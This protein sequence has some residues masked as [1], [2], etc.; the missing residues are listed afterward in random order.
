MRPALN[1]TSTTRRAKSTQCVFRPCCFALNTRHPTKPLP[2]P[3]R[4]FPW[5]LDTRGNRSMATTSTATLPTLNNHRPHARDF[6]KDLDLDSL[7]TYLASHT[8]SP[9]TIFKLLR[10]ALYNAVQ[11]DALKAW[12]I[13]QAMLDYRINGYLKSNHYGHLLGILKYGD[14]VETVPRMLQIL[15]QMPSDQ[16]SG[17]HLSQVLFAM[18]RQGQAREA[19]ALIK[20]YPHIELTANHYHSLAI[21]LKHA[22][23]QNPDHDL[24]EQVTQLMLEGMQHVTL[25]SSTLNTMISVLAINPHHQRTLDFLKAMENASSK[26]D[27]KGPYNVYIYTSLI[28]GFA[29]KGDT[30][31]AQQLFDQMIQHNVKPTQVTYGALMEA[32][33]RLGDFKTAQSL[34]EQA[35]KRFRKPNAVMYTSLLV[36]AIRHSDPIAYEIE[37]QIQQRLK[38]QEIDTML[39]TALMWLSAQRNVDQARK[40]L[41]TLSPESIHPIMLH[42][43][44]TAYGQKGDKANV[45]EIYQMLRQNNTASARSKHLLARA[46][47]Y[48]RDVPAAMQVFLS[49][50]SQ[51]IPDQVTCA[52][53]IQG[54]VMNREAELAWRLFR[55]LQQQ[56]IEPSVRAYTTILK[57][58]G[59]AD[60]M[61]KPSIVVPE[62]VTTEALAIFR[63]L[64]GFTEPHVYTYTTLIAC[65][66]KHDLNRAITI[67]DHMCTQQVAPTVETYTAL[68]QGCAIFRNSQMALNVFH[69]MCSRQ[70]EPNAVTWRYLLKSLLRSRADKAQI[71]RIG[72]MARKNLI[73]QQQ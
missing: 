19:C 45:I 56:G 53:V 68:L 49:M 29:R 23:K 63:R 5:F 41:S 34:L 8:L 44:M 66:A 12:V 43:L 60:Q 20:A 72:E 11:Y 22:I 39:R 38:P 15:Q 46:L 54:L 16:L 9:K 2:L 58:L 3:Q 35:E 30:K 50:R 6:N 36:N 17:Y 1:I 70:I 64:T 62:K 69:H 31:S 61:K 33:G 24:M 59:H 71:D 48:C 67:F 65:F 42:H 51:S 18:S 10:T 4:L 7:L 73:Q 32:Y 28:A 52:M 21:A 37:Q 55:S 40:T 47:F 26:K 25:S 14:S 27:E 13:Y 57:M